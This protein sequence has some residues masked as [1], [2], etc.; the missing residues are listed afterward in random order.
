MPAPLTTPP[1]RSRRADFVQAAAELFADRG[2]AGTS[3]DDVGNRLGVSGPA[4]Y[5]HFA[6]K[7]ALLTTM[8][9][10]TS[11]RLLAGGTR[12]V[13]EARDDHE[14]LT[15]LI[16][17]QVRFA[18]DHPELITV[19][20]RDLSHVPPTDRRRIRRT[21]RLYAEQWVRAL[22]GIAPEVPEERRRAATH[23][24]IGLI[25]STPYL[26]T[27]RDRTSISGLLETMA[28]AALY[29]ALDV[30]VPRVAAVDA[31]DRTL[32]GSLAEHG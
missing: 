21:Q 5:W 32:V 6:S 30:P 27:A 14:A 25:N 19:H 20:A 12:C 10:D 31:G 24:A 28:S 2:Y 11:D 17:W 3:V 4:V 23:A 22:G 1:R 16:R 9:A 15:N 7:E 29:R 18:L 8:L 26:E 13:T